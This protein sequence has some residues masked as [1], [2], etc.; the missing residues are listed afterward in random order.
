[1]SSN[2][3]GRF[4]LYVVRRAC[5][6]REGPWRSEPNAMAVGRCQDAMLKNA[7]ATVRC[8][9]AIIKNLMAMERF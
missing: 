1:M 3:H 6:G 9:D 2:V 7:M 5:E 8:Y 4:V